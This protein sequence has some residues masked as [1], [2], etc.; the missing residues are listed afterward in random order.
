MSLK[1]NMTESELRHRSSTHRQ[2]YVM[3]LE[4]KICLNVIL[5]N[6]YFMNEAPTVLFP[7]TKKM[8]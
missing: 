6:P 4:L 8:G 2:L 7:I 1:K 5:T 3:S